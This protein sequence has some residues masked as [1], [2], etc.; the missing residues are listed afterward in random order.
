MDSSVQIW[1]W[2]KQYFFLILQIYAGKPIFLQCHWQI[3][4]LILRKGV[5]SGP[6]WQEWEGCKII[7]HGSFLCVHL[8]SLWCSV[9]WSIPQGTNSS[10]KFSVTVMKAFIQF[11]K[12]FCITENLLGN[13]QIWLSVNEGS[14]LLN[15]GQAFIKPAAGLIFRSVTWKCYLTSWSC[16][17]S[18]LL[19]SPKD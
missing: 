1:C 17:F 9:D 13:G 6:W 14:F 12:C 11:L 7:W 16:F 5:Q 2:R 3:V 15:L 19:W 18:F 8:A 10:N 4:L